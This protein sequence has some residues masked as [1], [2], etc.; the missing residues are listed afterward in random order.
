MEV[1]PSEMVAAPMWQPTN[2]S[3]HTYLR[4]Y[5][6]I[7]MASLGRWANAL[8]SNAKRFRVHQSQGGTQPLAAALMALI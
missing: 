4:V 3:C 6:R 5:D 1:E 8:P 2:Q 7:S